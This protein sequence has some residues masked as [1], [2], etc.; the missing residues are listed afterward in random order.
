VRFALSGMP[1]AVRDLPEPL[2]EPGKVVLVGRLIR[3]GLLMRADI[4]PASAVV[5]DIKPA[6]VA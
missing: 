1:F 5:Q 4:P 6:R 3:E 2:D